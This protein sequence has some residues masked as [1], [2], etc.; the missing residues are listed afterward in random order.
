MVSTCVIENNI[1]LT[2]SCLANEVTIVTIE[3]TNRAAFE[4][5]FH[6]KLLFDKWFDSS[7]LN[8]RGMS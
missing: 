3:V 1:F 7:M 5:Q 8:E 4:R 2:L 6:L